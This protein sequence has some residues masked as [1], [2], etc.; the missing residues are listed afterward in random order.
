MIETES[1]PSAVSFIREL[2]RVEMAAWVDF[3]RAATPE[4]RERF[5]INV[6]SDDRQVQLT[7]TEIDTLALNRV[8]G[9][10]VLDHGERDIDGVIERYR[11]VRVPRCFVQASPVVDPTLANQLLRRGFEPYNNW[12]KLYRPTGRVPQVE[13]NLRVEAIG[14]DWAREFSEIFLTSFQ[15]EPALADWLVSAVGRANWKHYLAFDG[16]RPV[17]TS[18]AFF[19]G[20]FVWI[21]FAST[22]TEYRG[23]GAQSALLARR[24]RDAT[25]AGCKY[26]VVETAKPSPENPST[27][28][29]N[30]IRHGFV[31]AYNR[32]NYLKVL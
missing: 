28:H 14:V 21:D 30:M 2:E 25:E 24:I 1:K 7:V 13:T 29:R 10:R 5:G 15:W 31:S 22:L 11:R 23:R 8:F 12:V 27:S 19:Q 20:D 26:L 18:A 4:V 32:P 9:P 6:D 17:A 3:Y 16:D